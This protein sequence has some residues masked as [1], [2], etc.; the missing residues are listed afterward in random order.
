MLAKVICGLSAHRDEKKK[1]GSMFLYVLSS[2]HT[3]HCSP[4]AT[5]QEVG[6]EL[7]HQKWS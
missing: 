4:K 5:G 2:P 1:K 6:F 7:Q 3:S